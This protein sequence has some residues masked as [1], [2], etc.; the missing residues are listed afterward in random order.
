VVRYLLPRLRSR[1]V[2]TMAASLYASGLTPAETQQLHTPVYD[3]GRRGRWDIGA[4][5]RLAEI[6]SGCH[7]DIVHTHVF[8]GKYWGRTIAW[9]CRVPVIVH[10]E[11]SSHSHI[12]IWERL[13]GSL[14]ARPT[15]A[16]ITFSPRMAALV[17]RRDRAARIII[18][19]NGIPVTEY[20]EPAVVLSARTKLGARHS[21]VIG[22]LGNLVPSKNYDLAIQ[23]MNRCV[24]ERGIDCELH[25]FGA[26]PCERRIYRV[27]DAHHLT[28][29]VVVH[30]YR[31][32]ARSLLPGLDVFLSTATVE[33]API[34]YLEAM[35]AGIPIVATPTS[36]TLDM[37]V[38]GETGFI[39]R[40][41]QLDDVAT[42]LER[43]LRD[44]AWRVKAGKAAWTRVR[45]FYDI[46]H[47][48]DQH[49]RLYESLLRLAS[50]T[51]CPDAPLVKTV[52]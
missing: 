10:T 5:R 37:V 16:T 17:A 33:A 46:E 43:A 2:E 42:S 28:D 12:S 50:P 6:T 32:D 13:M 3:C 19:P 1:G 39:A 27:I 22:M 36:G 14:L 21:L 11:H 7:P 34:S 41:W 30:G 38:D 51:S 49:V 25:I 44:G 52:V 9:A 24:N 8:S 20:P 45:Q 31:A 35:V 23:V 4:L 40:S 47:V 15:R 18:I 29:R 48:A 26:G